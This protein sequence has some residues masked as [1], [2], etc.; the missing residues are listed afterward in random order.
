[1]KENIWGKGGCE[2]PN[3]RLCNACCV[4]PEIELEN[5]IVSVG[6]P[7][8]TPCPNLNS[9]EGGCKLHFSGKPD[10]CR[11]WHCSKANNDD[12]LKLIAGA[13]AL[14]IVGFKDAE[15]A[16]LGWVENEKIEQVTF[17]LEKDAKN[18][19]ENIKPRDLICRDLVEP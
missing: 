16:V 2:L 8:N 5:F 4:L 12:K 15:E 6:K 1:M 17:Q 9:F 19:A 3:G 14:G 10:T 18:L 13:L 7:E 11:N